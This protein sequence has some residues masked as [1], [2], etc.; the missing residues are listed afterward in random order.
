[1][2][3]AC[4]VCHR[5]TS[6]TTALGFIIAVHYFLQAFSLR[7]S[8]I[9]TTSSRISRVHFQRCGGLAMSSKDPFVSHTVRNH[10]PVLHKLAIRVL[11]VVPQDLP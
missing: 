8:F 4:L 3:L 2:C 5:H 10:S 1:M 11:P 9:S 6:S 7:F